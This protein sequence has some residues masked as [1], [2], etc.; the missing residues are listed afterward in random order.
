MLIKDVCK[1]C[2]VTKKAL[3]YYEDKGLISPLIMENG[4]QIIVKKISRSLK[5]FVF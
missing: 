2:H 1:L 5:K 3:V 4:Y